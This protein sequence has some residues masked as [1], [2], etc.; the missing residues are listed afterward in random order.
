[1]FCINDVVNGSEKCCFFELGGDFK[2]CFKFVKF[3]LYS[4][5]IV[6]EIFCGFGNEG[7]F[8]FGNCVK[9]YFIKWNR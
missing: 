1:M 3:F 4:I 9:V 7:V 8:N 6:D 5:F 2:I